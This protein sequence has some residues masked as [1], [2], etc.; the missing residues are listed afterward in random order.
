MFFPNKLEADKVMTHFDFKPNGK[1]K[2]VQIFQ[3][4]GPKV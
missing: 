4:L 3:N 1:L 2:G